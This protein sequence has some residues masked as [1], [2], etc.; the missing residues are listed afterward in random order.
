MKRTTGGKNSRCRKISFQVA[1][2]PGSEV[3]WVG[4]FSSGDPK[5]YQMHEDPDRGVYQVA[6]VLPPGRHEYKFAV[7]GEWRVDASCLDW[8]PDAM[9]AVNS[10]VSV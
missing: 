4:T 2:E 6:L 1:A 9:G 8:A 10:V 5:H 3:F 7:N